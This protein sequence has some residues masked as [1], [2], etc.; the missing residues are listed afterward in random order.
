VAAFKVAELDLKKFMGH[1]IKKR[2]PIDAV[3]QEAEE[4]THHV[5][6]RSKHGPGKKEKSAVR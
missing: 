2:R 3:L 5:R 6:E 4:I 1:K